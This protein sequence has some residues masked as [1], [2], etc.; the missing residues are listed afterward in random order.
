MKR[1]RLYP[2]LSGLLVLPLWFLSISMPA[3]NA[4]KGYKLHEKA[5][6]EKSAEIFREVA[7]ENDQDMAAKFGLALVYAD[8]KS[9]LF[10][11]ID[12]WDYALKTRQNLDKLTPD[13]LGFIGEY[14]LNTEV[15]PRSI[16]VKKKIQYAMETIE[17]K[18]IKYI[19][20]ENNLEIVYEVLDRFPDFH[21]RENVMHIRNQLEFRKYEKQNTLGAYLEFI[22][23]FP[24]AA[25][26]EKAIRYRNLLAFEKAR[27]TNTVD[28]FQD[29]L[30]NYPNATECNTVI[31]LLNAAAFQQARQE[32]SISAF[33]DFISTHPDALEVADARQLQKQL[34]YEYAKKIQT[35]EAY[36]EFIQKYPEGQQYIDIF[37]LKSLDSG[38]KFINSRH[39]PSSNLVWA[40]SFS[41]EGSQG[42]TSCMAV[43]SADSYIAGGTVV[44]TDTGTSDAWVIKMANDGKMTWNKFVGDAFNDELHL[45]GTN[46][47]NEIFGI[48]NTW[49]GRNSSSR[50]SWIFK[51]GPDGKKL[52]SKKLGKLDVTCILTTGQG[53]VYLGGSE[54]VDSTRDRHYAIMSLNEYGK[55]LWNRTYTG[56]GSIENLAFS[57]DGRILVIGN[58]WRAKMEPGGYLVW[59]TAFAEKDSILKSVILPRGEMLHLGLRN[60]NIVVLIKTG[61]DGKVIYE[62]EISKP[63]TLIT[64]SAIITGEPGQ[65][66][67]LMDFEGYQTL[68]WILQAKG[69]IQESIRIP[70]GVTI[71]EISRDLRGN[72]ILTAFNGE[73]VLIKNSG[74]NL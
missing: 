13:E 28:A 59:E 11:L 18:L 61:P 67:A 36:N 66:I 68:D 57:P 65:V 6:Y 43:D 17:A 62:K 7:I 41:D 74:I 39:F 70:E 21:Y 38:M 23:K 60:R 53:S 22:D 20:E 69:E 54:T 51:L 48:G 73:I 40:R 45:L 16:P 1:F 12:A 71:K 26:L 8:D 56:T 14:F 72:L 27:Q 2:I 49:L 9:S 31:R 52:W 63:D 47:R 46:G 55:R 33:D 4:K 37:N 19:R 30:K 64:S 34:L 3:Q 35:I 32:N 5:E 10:N 58:H 25:Q 29:F 24:D 42:F 50:E 15:R 44:R